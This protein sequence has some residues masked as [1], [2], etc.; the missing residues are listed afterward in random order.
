MLANVVVDVHYDP[1]SGK[2]GGGYDAG[3]AYDSVF[4]CEPDLTSEAGQGDE[5]VGE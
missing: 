3:A 1:L 5:E 4:W 2:E